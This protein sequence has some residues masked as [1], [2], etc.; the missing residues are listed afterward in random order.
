MLSGELAGG[1]GVLV[2]GV[3]GAGVLGAGVL[4]AP[5]GAGVGVGG[6]GGGGEALWSLPLGWCVCS[7]GCTNGIASSAYPSCICPSSPHNS[8]HLCLCTHHIPDPCK[9]LL[10]TAMGKVPNLLD[11]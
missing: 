8:S 11:A 9:P 5:V 2:G 6:G 10:A 3:L 1:G 4:V 7:L